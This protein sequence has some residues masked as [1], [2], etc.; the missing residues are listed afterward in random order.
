VLKISHLEVHPHGPD[1]LSLIWKLLATDD[2]VFRSDAALKKERFS[3]KFLE[4]S[5]SQL[6]VWTAMTTVWTTPAYI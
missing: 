4:N 5:V 1:A 2:Y 3:T 6:L